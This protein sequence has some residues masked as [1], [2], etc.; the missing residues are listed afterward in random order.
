VFVLSKLLWALVQPGNVLLLLLLAGSIVLLLGHRPLGAW[1]VCLVT[2]ALVAITFLPIGAWLLSPIENRFPLPELPER[3]D[4]V[5][6]LGDAVEIHAS[7]GRNQTALNEA[8]ERVTT[9]IE[10][11]R[12]YPEARLVVTGGIGRVVGGPLNPAQAL[13][14]FYRQQAF[15]VDRILF[16]DQS[17][18]TIENAVLT[19]QLVQ[20]KPGERWILVTSAYHMPR[21]VGVFRQAGWPVIAYPVDYRTTGQTDR[22]TLLDRLAQPSVSD[23]LFELDLAVKAWAG[24]LAYRLMGRTSALFPAP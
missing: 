13:K 15:D 22:W 3:V 21:S 8:A 6:M 1:L 14:S 10:L 16:E 23:A 12:R 20:P 24:L 2:A 17:R 7:A 4:G 19:R 5:V 11:G 18:N 9:L